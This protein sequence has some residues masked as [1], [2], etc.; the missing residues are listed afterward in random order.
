MRRL[1]QPFAR[2]RATNTPKK[3]KTIRVFVALSLAKGC[4]NASLIKTKFFMLPPQLYEGLKKLL[5]QQFNQPINN[6]QFQS[7]GGGSINENHKLTFSNAHTLFC[8]VN[9]AATFPQL[10]LKEAQGLEAL[11]KTATIKTPEII[12][13]A[14]LDNHQILILEWIESGPKTTS[15][16]KIF[17]EQLAAL[18]RNTNEHFGWETDNYMGSIPQQNAFEKDWNTFFIQQHLEPLIKQCRTKKL[19]SEKE[20]EDFKKLYQM[21]PQFFNDNE[22]PALLHGDL[23]SGNYMCS[24]HGE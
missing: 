19:L 12:L 13:N 23:W 14:V 18:H 17:G 20:H 2:L 6:L 4:K 3:L 21:L 5:A 24:R 15:F 22:K 9:H 1:E 11:K 8:K 10:F 16:F 7:I